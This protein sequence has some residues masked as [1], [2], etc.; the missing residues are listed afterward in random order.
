MWGA[1]PAGSPT[2]EDS[3]VAGVEVGAQVAGPS[4]LAG[5]HR[6][7]QAGRPEPSALLRALAF[8]SG[9]EKQ[10]KQSQVGRAGEGQGEKETPPN[11][12]LHPQR[13]QLS[14]HLEWQGVGCPGP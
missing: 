4:Q 2:L 9:K 7:V 12:P 6:G 14:W 11:R 13:T 1:D 5:E 3:R 10:T 8:N